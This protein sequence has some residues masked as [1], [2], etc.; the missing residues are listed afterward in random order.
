VLVLDMDPNLISDYLEM[1]WQLRRA[2]IPTELYL[3]A[4]RGMGKQL[5]YGDQCEIPVVLLFGAN[6]KATGKV[7][8]KDMAVGRAKAS[9]VAGRDEWLAAR[10]GQI[11]IKRDDLVDGVQALLAQIGKG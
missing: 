1:T 8:L 5:A 7:T 3:G 9:K 11:E 6:E 10:P 4:A 2:G